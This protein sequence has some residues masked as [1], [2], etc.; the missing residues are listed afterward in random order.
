[1]YLVDIRS[2]NIMDRIYRVRTMSPTIISFVFSTDVC[3]LLQKQGIAV[4]PVNNKYIRFKNLTPAKETMLTLM[5]ADN[6]Y[7]YLEPIEWIESWAEK[8]FYYCG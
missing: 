2:A 8:G 7:Y 4:E 6:K 3:W 5:I 1:M